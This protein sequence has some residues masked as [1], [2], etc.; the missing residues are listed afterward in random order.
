MD[1]M[2]LS[3]CDPFQ[4]RP[5][6]GWSTL[7]MVCRSAGLAVSPKEGPLV[8]FRVLAQAFGLRNGKNS[9][10]VMRPGRTGQDSHVLAESMGSEGAERYQGQGE[11]PTFTGG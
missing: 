3:T 1:P 6:A 10:R 5:V 2:L 7:N 11:E 4:V 9:L 8:V